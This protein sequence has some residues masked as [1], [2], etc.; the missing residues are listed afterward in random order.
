MTSEI[1][2]KRAT[3]NDVAKAA[4]VS[5]QTVSRVINGS[6][7]VSSKTRHRVIQEIEALGFQP[8]RAAQALAKRRTFTLEVISFGLSYFGPAQMLTNIERAAKTLGY[9]TM[10]S[11]SDD[12]TLEDL[13]SLG[14]ELAGLVDGV[15]IISPM[16]AS[17]FGQIARA[18]RGLPFIQVGN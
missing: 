3:L 2:P 12:M 7:Q 9:K 10:F 11:T 15:I 17:N 14:G 18:F 6:P 16:S 8:N 4:G 1:Y 5:Y 13:Q